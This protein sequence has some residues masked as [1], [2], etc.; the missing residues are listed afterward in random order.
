MYPSIAQYIG[1]IALVII[2]S[3]VAIMLNRHIEKRRMAEQEVRDAAWVQLDVRRDAGEEPLPSPEQENDPDDEPADENDDQ[4][5]QTR[6][7]Q[8]GHYSESKKPG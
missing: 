6:A 1:F 2:I 3:G 8:N 5:I 4:S 7:K